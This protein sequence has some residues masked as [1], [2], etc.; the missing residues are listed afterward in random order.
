MLHM[1]SNTLMSLA[2]SPSAQYLSAIDDRE[3]VDMTR[4]AIME[5]M[6]TGD[7]ARMALTM[8]SMTTLRM[9]MVLMME[10]A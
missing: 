9:L 2:R 4:A 5:A 6:P 7:T 10:S 1:M 8:R 3:Q